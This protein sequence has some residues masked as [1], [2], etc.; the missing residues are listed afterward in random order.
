MVG[1]GSGTATC[2]LGTLGHSKP[3]HLCNGLPRN[4][5]AA[6]KTCPLPPQ[7]P[8]PMARGLFGVAFEVLGDAGCATVPAGAV[9]A[10]A[11]QL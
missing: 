10:L 8:Q 4:P 7:N 9:A 2:N 11:I 6:V 3:M 1:V 5:G